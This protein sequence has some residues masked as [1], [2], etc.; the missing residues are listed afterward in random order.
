MHLFVRHSRS[1]P[2][3]TDAQWK[4]CHCVRWVTYTFEGKQH[5]ESTK[6]R[7]H[8]AAALFAREVE[9]KFERIALG[10]KPKLNTPTTIEQAVAAYIAD[11]RAQQLQPSTLSKRV[12]WFEKDLL[13]W[14]R[15]HALLFLTDLDL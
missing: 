13:G 7:N 4:R 3:K 12:L 1:C 14:C 10:E 11:K 2:H 15:G 9:K 5:R 6:K 8:E